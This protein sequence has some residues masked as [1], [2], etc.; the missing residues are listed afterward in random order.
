MECQSNWAVEVECMKTDP[1]PFPLEGDV[2]FGLITQQTA[3]QS[4]GVV[5][6]FHDGLWGW[7]CDDSFGNVDAS[8]AC[9]QLGYE[10]QGKIVNLSASRTNH[11][12]F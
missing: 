12:S 3:A 11:A 10:T 9:G 5:Q 1:I 2:R 8:V 4:R 7:I 6:V